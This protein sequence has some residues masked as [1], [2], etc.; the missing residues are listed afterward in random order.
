MKTIDVGVAGG[1]MTITFDRPG[2]LNSVNLE[3]AREMQALG[4]GLRDV[5]ARVIVLRGAGDA[6]MAGGDVRAF[7]AHLEDPAPLVDAIISGFH[8]FIRALAAAPQ[9]VLASIRGAAAGG[10][11]SLAMSADLAIASTDA[12]LAYAYRHLGVSPDGSGTWSLPRMVGSK[13]AAE[14]LLLRDGIGAQEALEFGLVNWV[15]EPDRLEEETQR[16]AGRLA[17]NAPGAAA[18]TKALLRRS[19][20]S[21]L[22]EQLDAEQEAFLACA[23]GP[24]FREGVTAFVG[25]RKPDFR[26]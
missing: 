13:R 26:S 17:A 19:L 25:K 22:E 2:A 10:G 23:R 15:V 24:E 14:I 21:G 8:G 11:L 4:D 12:R 18:R 16:I 7:H 9:P 1:I 5:D 6:F 3:M 20:A